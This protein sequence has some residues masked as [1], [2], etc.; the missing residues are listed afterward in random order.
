MISP[1]FMN[2][3]FEGMAI[4]RN[5]PCWAAEDIEPRYLLRFRMATTRHRK[6]ERREIKRGDCVRLDL[7]Y[8]HP[9]NRS[10][11]HMPSPS[12]VAWLFNTGDTSENWWPWRY[13]QVKQVTCSVFQ[14]TNN[15]ARVG[16]EMLAYIAHDIHG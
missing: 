10:A 15:H 1:A 12:Q 13:S 11:V 16:V 5:H 9:Y 4:F 8:F 14:N 2:V 6:A 7:K 3:F